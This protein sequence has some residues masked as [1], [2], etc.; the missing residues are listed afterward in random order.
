MKDSSLF[1][2]PDTRTR[3]E[4]LFQP[5]LRLN[6][7]VAAALKAKIAEVSE[8]HS[9]RLKA[10]LAPSTEE[11]PYKIIFRLAHRIPSEMVWSTM[12]VPA[13]LGEVV[14]S[15]QLSKFVDAPHVHDYAFR[16][17]NDDLSFKNVI[18]S[19]PP[20]L[21][22]EAL[23]LAT[24]AHILRRYSALNKR[25]NPDLEIED[26]FNNVYPLNSKGFMWMER[27]LL[28]G[29]AAL[30]SAAV[31][32]VLSE[33][34]DVIQQYVI[35]E[36]AGNAKKVPPYRNT[37]EWWRG[38]AN[39][40]NYVDY[41]ALINVDKSLQDGDSLHIIAGLVALAKR[42]AVKLHEV[43]IML[44]DVSSG[45]FSADKAHYPEFFRIFPDEEVKR[46]NVVSCSDTK[47]TAV[48]LEFVDVANKALKDLD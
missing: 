21:K 15:V 45:S 41:L 36:F 27:L 48:L 12:N 26:K 28:T 40:L 29:N 3:Y 31:R 1:S 24:Q 38:F 32:Q 16:H 7:L 2:I 18:H 34:P 11:M 47:S 46:Q 13:T 4:K 22:A 19:L 6:Q 25:Y 17:Y 9:K 39:Y 14:S 42:Y 33:H 8:I 5:E 23:K 43:K 37:L 20:T 44:G 35:Q 30:I 10:K